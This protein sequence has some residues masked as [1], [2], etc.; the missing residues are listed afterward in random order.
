MER[1]RNPGFSLT[2]H[3]SPDFAPLHPPYASPYFNAENTMR[4]RTSAVSE[5]FSV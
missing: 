5:Y 3:R 1:E 4:P 2:R